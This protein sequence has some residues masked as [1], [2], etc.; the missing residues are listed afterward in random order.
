MAAFSFNYNSGISYKSQYRKYQQ[1][2]NYVNQLDNAIRQAGCMSASAISTAVAVQTREVQNAITVSTAEQKEAIIQAS[3]AIC[4]SLESGFTELNYSLKDISDGIYGLSNL[5]GYGFSL[6]AESQKIT[7]KYLGQI[8]EL[9]RVSD[10]QKQR[11][12]HIEEGL[13]YLKNAYMQSSDSDFYTDALEEFKNAEEIEKK[14][15]IS[16]YHIGLI[17]LKSSKYYD[18][19]TAETYF[20]NSAK[21]YLAEDLIGGTNTSKSLYQSHGGFL[22]EA[23]EAYL[24]AAESCYLQQDFFEAAQLAGEAW[25]TFPE[26]TKAGLLHAKYLAA[27]ERSKE[28]ADVLKETININPYISLDILADS[29]LNSKQYILNL[30]ETLRMEAGNEAVSLFSSCEKVIIPNSIATSY[31]S[32]IKKLI[33]FSTFLESKKAIDLLLAPKQWILGSGAD[34]SSQGKIVG[35]LTSQEFT[36]NLFNFLKFEREYVL[37]LPK[38]KD[39][40]FGQELYAQKT[41]LIVE[42]NHFQEIVNARNKYISSRWRFWSLNLGGIALLFFFAMIIGTNKTGFL[43]FL[44]V[45]AVLISLVWLVRLAYFTIGYVVSSIEILSEV[46]KLKSKIKSGENKIKDINA[47]INN[48][49][50]D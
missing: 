45:L 4:S 50:M 43:N 24:F 21:Y 27:N 23:A 1:N 28:A 13:K 10:D 46:S 48:L 20:R 26:L 15:F 25:K 39:L 14:D 30:I 11:V 33:K 31:L 47:K 36:G 37:A 38:A 40:I 17:H 49:N 2:Q 34:I 32:T 44:A 16:L 22:R 42:I 7:H 9:L 18:P 8:Q 12:Y 5:V 6:L 35:I 3:N 41:A 29:D 19:K